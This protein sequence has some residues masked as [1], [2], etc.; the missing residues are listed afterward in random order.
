M[1]F[2]QSIFTDKGSRA[3][4]EDCA[5][6]IQVKDRHCFIVCDGLGGHGMG[7]VASRLAVKSFKECFVSSAGMEE[8]AA[9]SFIKV[10]S[11]LKA[12]QT[13]DRRLSHMRTTAVVLCTEGNR[14]TALHIGDSR[15]Y[16]FRNGKIISQTKDHSV[17]QMLAM[18]GEI[19]EHEIRRHPD[20][21]RLLRALGDENEEVRFVRSDF[22]IKEGDAFLLCSDGFWEE[23]EEES[24]EKSLS[25]N[26]KADKWLAEMVALAKESGKDRN[27]DNYTALAVMVD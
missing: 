7:D 27:M 5:D 13:E 22:E 25:R 18:A 3:V 11:A 17:P 23:V 24:K 6:H 8:F 20:R 4:N 2:T 9:D 1:K 21:N 14:G 26:K 16:H 19:S 12:A 10:Q 15:L